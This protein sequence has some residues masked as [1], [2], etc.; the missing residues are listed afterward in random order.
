MTNS[1][2]L[3]D[4]IRLTLREIADLPPGSLEPLDE[5]GGR[6]PNRAGWIMLGGLAAATT[7]IVVA[8]VVTLNSNDHPNRQVV[9]SQPPATVS[10]PSTTSGFT[11]PVDAGDEQS[12]SASPPP[13]DIDNHLARISGQTVIAGT[14]HSFTV[15]GSPA[16]ETAL[17]IT[18]Q[19]GVSGRPAGPRVEAYGLYWIGVG[20][21]SGTG[22]DGGFLPVNATT[23]SPV[24]IIAGWPQ[25]DQQLYVWPSIPAGTA[26]VTYTY[27]NRTLFWERPS[28]G[29]VAL[30]VPRPTAFNGNYS[31]WHTAPLPVLSAFDK[32]GRLLQQVEAP[33]IGGDD[34]KTSP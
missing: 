7:I 4:R 19:R 6:H 25:S 30:L 34:L 26:Y 28:A 27:Q 21:L 29:I 33:R 15:A 23:E 16:F 20:G 1:T 8:M 5:A 14:S 3:E 12:L 24:E 10:P 2:D 9:T 11:A 17:V 13:F 22:G 31:T 32:Q 18:Q